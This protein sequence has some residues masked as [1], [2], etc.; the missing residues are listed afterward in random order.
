MK[1]FTI[2]LLLAFVLGMPGS[3]KSTEELEYRV[4]PLAAEV[5]KS[6]NA[7]GWT[8]CGAYFA[9]LEGPRDKI[10]VFSFRGYRF[11]DPFMSFRFVDVR[12]VHVSVN[13]RIRDLTVVIRDS[14]SVL[15]MNLEDYKVALPCLGKGEKI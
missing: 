6:V 4:I 7:N 5:L 1:S 12:A 10:V 8:E 9:A 2:G 11:G 3:A 13:E 15:R 14:E